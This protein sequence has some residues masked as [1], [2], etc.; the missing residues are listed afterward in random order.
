[1]REEI[2]K[3][4]PGETNRITSTAGINLP[5]GPVLELIRDDAGLK[6]LVADDNPPRVVDRFPHGDR[7]YVPPQIHDSIGDGLVLPTG[8]GQFGSTRQLFDEVAGLLA[9]AGCGEALVPLTFSVFA[10]WFAQ[11]ASVAPFLWLVAPQGSS[12]SAL[13]Q[14]LGL[15]CRH[16]FVINALL[17]DWPSRLPMALQPTLIADI[18]RPSAR[19]LDVLRASQSHGMYP[20]RPGQVVDPFCAK[21]I[22]SR[23]PLGEPVDA[24][25]PLEIVL[26]STGKYVEPLEPLQAA[27]VAEEFQNKLLGYYMAN[28]S[29]VAPP[30]FELGKASTTTRAMAHSLAKAIVD[31]TDLQAKIAPYL[32]RMDADA[33]ME[34]GASLNATI[35]EALTTRRSDEEFSV[36]DLAG[37]VNTLIVGRGGSDHVT[38]ETLGWKLKGLGLR[39]VTISRG[40]KGLKMVD[41]RP[42]IA[43][44]AAAYGFQVPEVCL[45]GPKLPG[46]EV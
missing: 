38:P 22:F 33:A 4:R 36:S 43:K 25:S 14:M 40:L 42:T 32:L 26:T 24:G 19:L 20:T 12:T 27:R 28:F 5:D 11:N 44:L 39:T 15:L 30:K 23:D 6:L 17:G 8:L 10:S 21:L 1:L 46:V 3:V 18:E 7:T 34:S 37:D 35:V 9:R 13:K 16:P 31:D 41:A 45:C 2:Y 29:E